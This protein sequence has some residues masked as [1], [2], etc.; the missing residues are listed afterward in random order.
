MPGETRLTCLVLPPPLCWHCMFS[1]RDEDKL[2]MSSD[3]NMRTKIEMNN[4]IFS[5]ET[6]NLLFRLAKVRLFMSIR[7]RIH[8]NILFNMKNLRI[9]QRSRDWKIESR[10]ELACVRRSAP[11][12]VND[13]TCLRWQHYHSITANY[14]KIMQKRLSLNGNTD[15]LHVLHSCSRTTVAIDSID[16]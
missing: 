1:L 6:H 10:S 9:S 15:W 7:V 2:N 5:R 11:P 8:I 4:R 14:T 13:F 3:Y 16:H 12:A